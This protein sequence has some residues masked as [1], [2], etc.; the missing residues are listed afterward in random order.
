MLHSPALFDPYKTKYETTLQYRL[1]MLLGEICAYG[2]VI[3]ATLKEL[4]IMGNFRRDRIRTLISNFISDGTIVVDDSGNLF[5][6][7]YVDFDEKND[8]KDNQYVRNYVFLTCDEFLKETRQVRNFVLKYVGHQRVYLGFCRPA[9]VKNL[10][11]PDGSGEFSA[12]TKGEM[13]KIISRAEKYLKIRWSDEEKKESFQVVGVKEKWLEMGVRES[14]GAN[15]WIEKQL[16]KHGF[17]VE[18]V[19]PE[20]IWQLAKCMEAYYRKHGYQYAADVFDRALYNVRNAQRFLQLL[21]N[22]PMLSS[23]DAKEGALSAYFTEV[24]NRAEADVAVQICM[25]LEDLEEE[26]KEAACE[27]SFEKAAFLAKLIKERKDRLA[28][29]HRI[30]IAQFTENPYKFTE[31]INT[32]FNV[33]YTMERYMYELTKHV[34]EFEATLATESHFKMLKNFGNVPLV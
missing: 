17:V 23:D 16:D 3:P 1:K 25:D 20:A 22:D 24:M 21:Y 27:R 5:L 32:N 11:K 28:S 4:A 8:S 31:K 10:F 7:E 19:Q 26:Q 29:I 2:G 14:K 30:W 6:K 34:R 12:R 18:F 33:R 15:L 9:K 13:L